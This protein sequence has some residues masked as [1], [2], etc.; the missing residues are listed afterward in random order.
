MARKYFIAID[1]QIVK[2]AKNHLSVSPVSLKRKY[3][4]A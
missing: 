3:K 2:H 4:N 1:N